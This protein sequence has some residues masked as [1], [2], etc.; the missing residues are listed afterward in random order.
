MIFKITKLFRC[1]YENQNPCDLFAGDQRKF[2]LQA[3]E[4]CFICQVTLG[5]NV[6]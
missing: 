5:I 1:D 3:F 2:A 4:C 6:R